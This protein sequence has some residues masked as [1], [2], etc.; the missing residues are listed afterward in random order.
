VGQGEVRCVRHDGIASVT[1][2]RPE[3]RNAMTWTMYE[4]FLEILLGLGRD[5]HVRV[6]VLRG[7]GGSFIAGTDI[8]Q[9]TEFTTGEQGVAYEGRIEKVLGALEDIAV[10]TLAVVDGY[11]VG[12]GLAI[13]AACDLRVCTPDARFGLP[14]ART[15]GNCLS[16]R[17]YARLSALMGP[18]RL[19]AMIM[20]ARFVPA[21]EAL[22]AGWVTEVAGREEL[23]GRVQEICARLVGCAPL[24]IWATKTSLAR[25]AREEVPADR[26]IIATVYGSSDF[27]EGVSAF[28][29]KRA[30]Q[31][32]DRAPVPAGGGS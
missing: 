28:L 21:A 7:E 9:F 18:A 13:A 26:D 11:A 24:T 10:P 25:L 5:P 15:L 17:N 19:R 14:I 12:G 22:A 16:M 2:A 3:A 6:V 30:P 31:W 8:A 32:R 20:T 23:E 4:Q 27:R 29:G 1:F